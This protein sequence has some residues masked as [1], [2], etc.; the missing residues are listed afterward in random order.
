LVLVTERR[1]AILTKIL[2]VD[3]EEI[4][5]EEVSETLTDVGYDCLVASNVEAALN[6]VK[7]TPEITLIL[8][9][10]KMPGLT[11][12]DLIKTLETKPRQTI[13]F[14]VMSGHARPGVEKNGIDLAL[15]PFLKKP[16]DVEY[17][18][19]IVSLVLEAKQ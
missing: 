4:I 6:I 15:Y 7:T 12:A 2:I 10:L 3:D 5:L 13:K 1:R 8:T 14:I 11:G 9:D 18:L 19:E 16:L 17:L